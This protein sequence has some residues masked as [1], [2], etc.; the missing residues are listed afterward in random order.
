[1]YIV[2]GSAMVAVGLVIVSLL[3]LMFRSAATPRWL[4]SDLT[5]MLLALPAAG[6]LALGIGSIAVGLTHGVGL[7]EAAALIGCAA[8]L[9]GVRW[10]IR[11]HLPTPVAV[12]AAGLEPPASP[13][14]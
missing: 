3:A 10:L 9:L 2:T 14:P 6:L 11:R 13:A 1:M 12:S 5:A 8:L 7:R 4:R